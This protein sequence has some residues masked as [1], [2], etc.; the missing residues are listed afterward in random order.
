M[1]SLVI[2][3]MGKKRHGKDT[4]ASRLITEHGFTR[5]AFADPMRDGI[6]GLNPLVR[7]EDDEVGPLAAAAYPDSI[8]FREGRMIR[9]A[10]LVD[11]VGWEAAKATREV[12]RLL[13]HYGTGLRDTLG[14]S[15][16]VDTTLRLAAEVDGPVVI[17]DVRFPNEV[18]AVRNL[19]GLR[20]HVVRVVNPRVPVD[21]D[22]HIS[23]TAVDDVE[24]DFAV[25]ND[26]TIADLHGAA[27]HVLAGALSA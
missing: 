5:L 25:V 18:D 6:Y 27:D 22:A 21:G 24:P 2:G 11:L 10:T 9:L 16:W 14:E 23:E 26:G 20:G 7:I 17:T 13:Q 19:E 8:G 3:V 12:R 1:A 15:I 4:F